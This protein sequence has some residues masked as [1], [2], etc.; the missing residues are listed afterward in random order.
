M[1]AVRKQFLGFDTIDN[2][3]EIDMLVAGKGE[4]PTRAVPWREGLA[5][6]IRAE[7][8]AEFLGVRER[9]PDARAWRVDDDATRDAVR[10]RAR[11]R[12][13]FVLPAVSVFMLPPP[14]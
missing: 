1:P 11:T 2:R 9:A 4:R 10:F 13:V 6:Q 3:I 7:P 8:V 12:F 14:L 5:L